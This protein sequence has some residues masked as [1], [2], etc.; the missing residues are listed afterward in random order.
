MS[1]LDNL[2]DNL[3]S[4]ESGGEREGAERE[5]GLREA[6]KARTMAVAPWAEKLKKSAF[7]S[8]LLSVATR[9]GFKQRTKVYITW[10][11]TTLRLEARNLKLELRPAHDGVTAAFIED[12]E[13][14]QSRTIDLS[15]DPS[16]LVSEWLVLPEQLPA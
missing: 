16:D 8:Q 9:A 13:E 12:K 4:L 7:T 10:V 3:K 6:E 5:Q 15:G 11:G 2:E 1:F 14:T